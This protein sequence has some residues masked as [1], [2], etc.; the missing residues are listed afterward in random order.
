VLQSAIG[1]IT[2]LPNLQDIFHS[3][4]SPPSFM[5]DDKHVLYS[6]RFRPDTICCNG[7]SYGTLA[8]KYSIEIPKPVIEIYFGCYVSAPKNSLRNA[9]LSLRGFFMPH[10]PWFSN[11]KISIEYGGKQEDRSGGSVQQLE[12]IARSDALDYLV[13]EPEPTDYVL[14]WLSTHGAAFVTL[15]AMPRPS[16]RVSKRKR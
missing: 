12:E 3:Y 11:D 15:K 5:K 9:P 6:K 1:E 8:N 7:N 13:H 2:L 14:L 10:F 16:R 4:V